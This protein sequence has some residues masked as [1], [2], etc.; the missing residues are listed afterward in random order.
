LNRYIINHL[1]KTKERKRQGKRL[2]LYTKSKNNKRIY[3][4]NSDGCV[5]PNRRAANEIGMIDE[6]RDKE[7]GA[8]QHIYRSW[9]ESIK[10]KQGV[11][12]TVIG[13]I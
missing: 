12:L 3:I 5:A 4:Y 9:R 11:D 7:Q 6:P 8:Q 13:S 10:R 1:L 2:R